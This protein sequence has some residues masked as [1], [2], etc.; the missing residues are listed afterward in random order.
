MKQY[1]KSLIKD[2]RGLTIGDMYP[3]VLSLVL[4]VL[5]LGVGALVLDKLQAKVTGQAASAIANGTAGIVD[6]ATWIPTIVIV[7]AAAIILGLVI[8]SFAARAEV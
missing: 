5:V 7:I 3:I 4:I 2:K 6:L 1:L 8:R